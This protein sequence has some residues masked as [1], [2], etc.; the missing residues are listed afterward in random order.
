MLESRNAEQNRNTQNEYSVMTQ[1][2]TNI[3]QGKTISRMISTLNF[4]IKKDNSIGLQIADMI[5]LV[6]VRKLHKK[7]NPYSLYISFYSKLYKAGKSS[8]DGYGLINVRR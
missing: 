1:F 7:S 3:Y 5:P 2:G 6:L 4:N 8:V